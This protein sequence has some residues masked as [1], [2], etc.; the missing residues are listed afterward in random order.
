MKNKLYIITYTYQIRALT[1]F[2]YSWVGGE[3]QKELGQQPHKEKQQL[4]LLFRELFVHTFL[5]FRI[6][7]SRRKRAVSSAIAMFN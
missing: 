4:D 6:I 5:L 1:Q 7:R 3:W 2:R